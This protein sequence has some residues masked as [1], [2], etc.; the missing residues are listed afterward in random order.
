MANVRAVSGVC[1]EY[2]IPLYIDACRFAENAY[3]IKLRE[4]GYADRRPKLQNDPAAAQN[5][6]IEIMVREKRP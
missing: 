4:E 2:G 3:F 6:R 1:K 5:R